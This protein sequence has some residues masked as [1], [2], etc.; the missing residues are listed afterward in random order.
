MSA[1][2]HIIL[3]TFKYFAISRLCMQTYKKSTKFTNVASSLMLALNHLD[4]SIELNRENEF[5]LWQKT[6]LLPT[7]GSCIFLLALLAH[8]SNIRT[9]VIVENTEYRFPQSSKIKNLF[10]SKKEIYDAKFSSELNLKEAKSKGL[11]VEIRDFELNE[12]IEYLKQN[13]L[14]LLRV[15]ISPLIKSKS[16]P[17]Y[18]LL[19]GFGNDKFLWANTFEGETTRIPKEKLKECFTTLKTK[20]K[21]DNKMII[22]G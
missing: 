14:V 18:I 16:I 10:F 3:V 21:R 4:S 11:D 6:V 17:D 22:F 1:I 7:R 13:K 12:V 15:N 5:K 19:Y 8:Q 20:C 2:L 9:K